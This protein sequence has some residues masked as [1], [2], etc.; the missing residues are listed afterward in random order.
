M[1]AQGAPVESVQ[2]DAK[3]MVPWF[4]GGTLSMPMFG[5]LPASAAPVTSVRNTAIK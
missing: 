4:G 2:G 5:D 3:A 1:A